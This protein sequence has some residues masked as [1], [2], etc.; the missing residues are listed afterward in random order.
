MAENYPTKFGLQVIGISTEGRPIYL[1]IIS[2]DL[3]KEIGL[4]TFIEAGSNGSDWMAISSALFLIESLTRNTS[5]TMIMT[6][7][8]VPCSN[9]DAY[10]NSMNTPESKNPN[11]RMNLTKNFPVILGNKDLTSIH[12]DEFLKAI[13]FWKE[14]FKYGAPETQALINA[15]ATYQIAL[16]LFVSLE[17]DGQKILYPF[18]FCNED[19]FDVNDLKKIAKSAQSRVR[20][21]CFEVGS[22]YQ[23]CGLTFGSLPDFLRIQKSPMRFTYIIHVNTKKDNPDPERILD[24]GDDILNCIKSMAT[25][26]YMFYNKSEKIKRC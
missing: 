20:S 17:E 5:L 24:C 21:R 18:G 15:I 23:L 6:Y 19:I 10:H 2:D 9:P 12:T 25:N 14:N 8:I 1:A 26:V 13:N 4:G 16:R 3:S 7:F 11:M 22:T